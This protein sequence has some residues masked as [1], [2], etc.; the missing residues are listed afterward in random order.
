MKYLKIQKLFLIML[1]LIIDR[2]S[3]K[4]DNISDDI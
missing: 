3:E 1:R 2:Q 4:V